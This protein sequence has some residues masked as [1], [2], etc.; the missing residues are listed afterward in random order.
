MAPIEHH[1]PA[2]LPAPA[3]YAHAS[4]A[5]DLVFIGGQVGCD[6]SGRIQEP[7]DVAAQFAR[8]IANVGVALKAAGC[9]ADDVIKLTYL[10]TD[11][12]AYRAA[13]KPIGAAYRTVFGRNFPASTLIEVKGLYDP[14]ALVEIEAVAVRSANG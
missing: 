7:S 8:A 4:S 12:A 14:D 5:G 3:G 9:R 2:E 10:V 13:R 1:N 11:V 6:A